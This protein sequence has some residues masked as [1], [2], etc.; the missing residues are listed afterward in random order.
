MDSFAAAQ[1]SAVFVDLPALAQTLQ[2][3]LAPVELPT[4]TPAPKQQI[5][6]TSTFTPPT[7]T[8]KSFSIN[9]K[10]PVATNLV[11]T[12]NSAKPLEDEGDEELD[13]LLGLQKSGSGVG[14]NQ[15]VGVTEESC[16][17]MKAAAAAPEVL[18]EKM[19]EVK[20]KDVTPPEPAPVKQEMTE[21]D[22]EDWL[23]SMIS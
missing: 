6:K 14:G 7:T 5:S 9:Q 13:Q 2:Q 1:T 11:S 16:E 3:V 12:S 15:C 21:E 17:E 19:E 23:D 8:L 22:L 10:V 4:V 18:E 20:D